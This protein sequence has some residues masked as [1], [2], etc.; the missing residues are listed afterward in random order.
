LETAMSWP[1]RAE[2]TGDGE[3]ELSE[4][5]DMGGLRVDDDPVYGALE[6]G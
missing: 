1:S 2:G 6:R 3:P 5:R 4:W